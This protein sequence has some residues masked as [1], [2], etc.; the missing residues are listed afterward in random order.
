MTA[1][2]PKTG[3]DLLGGNDFKYLI[4]IYLTIDEFFKRDELLFTKE[5]KHNN[6]NKS[7]WRKTLVYCALNFF[8]I[9]I[10]LLY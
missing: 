8:S 3:E 5:K 1:T 4:H 10:Y 9:H 7:D 2:P 6:L